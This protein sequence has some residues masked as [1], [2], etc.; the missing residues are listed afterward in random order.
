MHES[1]CTAR[2]FNA[3]RHY[4]ALQLPD[5]RVHVYKTGDLMIKA[6][7]ESLEDWYN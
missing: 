2:Y 5:G 1:F 6:C 4:P 3:K 7:Y